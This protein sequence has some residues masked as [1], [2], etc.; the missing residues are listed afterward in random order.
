MPIYPLLCYA[1]QWHPS[2]RCLP[3]AWQADPPS[4]AI[5]TKMANVNDLIFCISVYLPFIVTPAY[6]NCTKLP[7]NPQHDYEDVYGC[8]GSKEPRTVPYNRILPEP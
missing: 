2:H 1:P 8:T 4:A 3:A 7:L 5:P 6:R